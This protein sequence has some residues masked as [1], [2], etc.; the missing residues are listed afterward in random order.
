MTKAC[1][2]Q[3]P[4]WFLRPATTASGQSTGGPETV[5]VHNGPITLLA[6]LWR[7]PGR[8]PFS[9]DPAHGGC[10]WNIYF[11][12]DRKGT[13]RGRKWR[14]LDQRRVKSGAGREM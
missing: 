8:G 1:G 14:R 10:A 3:W 6:L 12:L 13:G 9:G 7:P 4:R 5:V 11:G 2:F